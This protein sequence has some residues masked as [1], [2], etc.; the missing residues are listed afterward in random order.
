MSDILITDDEAI[1]IICSHP[2]GHTF[3]PDEVAEYLAKAQRDKDGD[4]SANED[5]ALD[6]LE[7]DMSTEM[8]ARVTAYRNNTSEC[9]CKGSIRTMIIENDKYYKCPRCGGLIERPDFKDRI[10]AC[11][12]LTKSPEAKYHTSTCP[13]SKL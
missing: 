12:C 6:A 13:I 9:K 11:T 1:D 3:T 10:G 8:L 7:D 2:C 4:V 5:D